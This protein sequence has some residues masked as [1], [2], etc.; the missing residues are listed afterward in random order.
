MRTLTEY[1]AIPHPYFGIKWPKPQEVVETICVR[2]DFS[3]HDSLADCYAVLAILKVMG[4]SEETNGQH[5]WQQDL[6]DERPTRRVSILDRE[7]KQ[8][9]QI[10]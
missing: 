2:D 4:N 7:H 1:C 6:F 3:F 8:N 9:S 5:K 10:L